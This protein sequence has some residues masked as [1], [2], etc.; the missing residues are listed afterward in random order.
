MASMCAQG[1]AVTV[2]AVVV[3]VFFFSFDCLFDLHVCITDL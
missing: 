2:V 3:V 1:P